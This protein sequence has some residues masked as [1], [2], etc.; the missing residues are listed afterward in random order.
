MDAN[1][2]Q[3]LKHLAMHKRKEATSVYHC[4]LKS[5]GFSSNTAY[6]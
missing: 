4:A 3:F 5:A 6:I 2:E 1:A